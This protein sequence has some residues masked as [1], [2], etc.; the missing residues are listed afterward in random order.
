ML[1][2]VTPTPAAWTEVVLER[3]S[4]KE[5]GLSEKILLIGVTHRAKSEYDDVQGSEVLAVL[6]QLAEQGRARR[7]AGRWILERQW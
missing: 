3:L 4:G 5:D 7:T 2:L 6:K 1:P